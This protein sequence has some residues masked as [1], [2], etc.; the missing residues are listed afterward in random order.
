[1]HDQWRAIYL[2]AE[3][4]AKEAKAGIW[5]GVFVRP[6]DWRHRKVRLECE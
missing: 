2:D 6:E 5:G 4:K 1:M 3:V